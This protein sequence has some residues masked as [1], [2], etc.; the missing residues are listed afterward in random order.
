MNDYQRIS[1]ADHSTFELAIMRAQSMRVEIN[2]E[3]VSIKPIDL[4]TKKGAEFLVFINQQNQQQTLRV[5][6][7]S[8]LR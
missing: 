6:Q 1:C 7:V 5:D 8:I 4:I 3:L 2:A